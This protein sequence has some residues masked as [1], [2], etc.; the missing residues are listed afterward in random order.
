MS[1]QPSLSRELVYIKLSELNLDAGLLTIHALAFMDTPGISPAEVDWVDAIITTK[2]GED[3]LAVMVGPTRGDVVTTEALAD[4]DYQVWV[5]ASVD[6]TGER[7]VR[8]AG[9][10]SINPMGTET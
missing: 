9:V 6:V 4:A 3:A 5:D 8:P 7:V 10:H 1:A 2:D